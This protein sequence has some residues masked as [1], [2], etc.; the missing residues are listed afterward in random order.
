MNPIQSY[1]L[2]CGDSKS[3]WSLF[4][5]SC[6]CGS[7]VFF[8]VTFF[9]FFW[10]HLYINF[11]LNKTSN[12]YIFF[13]FA[14]NFTHQFRVSINVWPF[15]VPATVTF[16]LQGISD[17][18]WCNVDRL[19]LSDIRIAVIPAPLSSRYSTLLVVK[20]LAVNIRQSHYLFC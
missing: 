19:Y 6:F 4:L 5:C 12:N 13:G 2:S 17:P 10:L 18:P 20:Y 8:S 11:W 9:F 3:L 16:T 7:G 14:V 15:S 1:G